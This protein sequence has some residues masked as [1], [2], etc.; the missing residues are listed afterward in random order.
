MTIVS[1]IHFERVCGNYYSIWYREGIIEHIKQEYLAL[2]TILCTS[3][4]YC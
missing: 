3:V 2:C 1:I 4:M